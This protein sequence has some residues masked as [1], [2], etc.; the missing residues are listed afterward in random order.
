MSE[1]GGSVYSAEAIAAAFH[2]HYE[3]LAPDFGYKTREASA[4][5]W[6]NIPQQNRDLMVAVVEDLLSEGVIVR[7]PAQSGRGQ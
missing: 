1:P 2:I 4:V 7:G 5:P 3:A 6:E